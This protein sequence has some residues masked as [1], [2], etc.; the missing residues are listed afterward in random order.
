MGIQSSVIQSLLCFNLFII[1]YMLQPFISTFKDSLSHYYFHNRIVSSSFHIFY[2]LYAMVFIILCDA[3]Y[4]LKTVD[5]LY[6]SAITEKDFY[7]CSFTLFTGLILRRII[8][9]VRDIHVQNETN[10]ENTKQHGNSMVFVKT[11]I[12]EKEQAETKNEELSKENE[13]LKRL[14]DEHEGIYSE[15]KNNKAAYLKLK[16]K[17]EKLRKEKYGES[18]KNK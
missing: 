18:R 4:K 9:I 1:S 2:V 17:Y 6:I 11:V 12:R 10:Q 8:S 16:E 15:L 7:L 5:S 3:I 14:I 13:R